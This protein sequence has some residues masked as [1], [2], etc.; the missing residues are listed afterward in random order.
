MADEKLTYQGAPV[1]LDLAPGSYEYPTLTGA[2]PKF[3]M[4]DG[5]VRVA[6]KGVVLMGDEIEDLINRYR[7]FIAAESYREQYAKEI[8]AGEIEV[9]VSGD[10]TI[11]NLV[12]LKPIVRDDAIAFGDVVK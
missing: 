11:V 12:M 5:Q 10:G 7:A 8:A 4:L 1:V 3:D 6:V 9:W 2:T